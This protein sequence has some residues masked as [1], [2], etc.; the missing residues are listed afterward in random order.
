MAFS[1]T[2]NAPAPMVDLRISVFLLSWRRSYWWKYWNIIS[3]T[4]SQCLKL[5]GKESGTSLW[6]LWCVNNSFA[7]N[8]G[9]ECL[10]DLL[11]LTLCSE[12]GTPDLISIAFPFSSEML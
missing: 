7:D 3:D 4:W 12:I 1:L 10:E 11:Q 9:A 2:G 6:L 8:Q 5:D